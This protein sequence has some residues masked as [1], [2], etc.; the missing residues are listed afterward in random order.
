[1]KALIP[2]EVLKKESLLVYLCLWF[3]WMSF[4]T[5]LFYLTILSVLPVDSYTWTEFSSKPSRYPML[6]PP[7][8]HHRPNV[9]PRPPRLCAALLVPYLIKKFPGHLIFLFS[10]FGSCA[11]ISSWRQR[12]SIKCIGRTRLW[13]EIGNVWT[14]FE[15]SYGPID[16]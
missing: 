12:R 3:G 16:S 8:H 11:P 14:G 9:S 1:M 5:Y 2:I 13:D 4:G 6:H 7:P 15:F 10:M